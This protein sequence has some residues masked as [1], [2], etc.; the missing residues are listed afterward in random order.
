MSMIFCMS[1]EN[2]NRILIIEEKSNP[3]LDEIIKKN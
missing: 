1:I 2:E 3:E